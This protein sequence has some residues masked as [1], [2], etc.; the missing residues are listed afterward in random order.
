MVK[1]GNATQAVKE[2]Y[3]V[4]NDLTARVMGSQN[5]TKP[6]IVSALEEHNDLFKNTITDTVAEYSKSK[7]T[8]KRALAVNTAKWGYEQIHGKAT[9]RTESVSA[10][11]I[12]HT[13]D[14]AK[15]YQID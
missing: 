15:K 6:N 4:K 3:N 11:F 1:T 9:Q 12:Q 8:G 10:S 5:L 13:S 14:K 2:V 7:D